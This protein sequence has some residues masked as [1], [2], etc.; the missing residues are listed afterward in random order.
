M[1]PADA[2]RRRVDAALAAVDF[3]YDRDRPT[4]ALSGGEQQRLASRRPSALAPGLL[5]LDEPTS[6]LDRVRRRDPDRG[7]RP[8]NGLGA[9]LVLVEHRVGDWLPNVDRVIG[10]RGGRWGSGGRTAPHAV[11]R[12]RHRACRAP[13]S[14]SPTSHPRRHRADSRKPAETLV[15]AEEAMYRYRDEL[16]DALAATSVTLRSSEAVACRPTGAASRPW[17]S[18]SPA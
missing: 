17:R 2:L 3:P 16:R 11:R 7:R 14:G 8:S 12:A 6:N 10:P 4:H 1:R 5:L 13:A 15:I 18:C 9:T